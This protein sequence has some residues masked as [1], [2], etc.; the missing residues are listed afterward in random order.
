MPIHPYVNYAVALML[1]IAL[2]GIFGQPLAERGI[3]ELFKPLGSLFGITP[4]ASV[5]I[6]PG[7]QILKPQFRQYK[8]EEYPVEAVKVNG[9]YSGGDCPAGAQCVKYYCGIESSHIRGT[10]CTIEVMSAAYPFRV[11][12]QSIPACTQTNMCNAPIELKVQDGS[13][14][15]LVFSA[16]IFGNTG[17]STRL[18]YRQKRLYLYDASTGRVAGS[19]VCDTC[20]TTCLVGQSVKTEDLRVL[21]VGEVIESVA[22]WQQYP[23]FDG[24]YIDWNGQPAVCMKTGSRESIVQNL[25]KWSNRPCYYYHGDAVLARGE[26]CPGET[27]LGL[28]C[29]PVTLKFEGTTPRCCFGSSCSVSYCPGSG[30][31]PAEEWNMPGDEICAYFCD[32][33]TGFC[34]QD[35]STCETW[36]C[37]PETG[38]GCPSTQRCD[39]VTKTCTD[40]PIIKRKCW[41]TGR[42]CCIEPEVDPKYVELLTCAEAGFPS[43]YV[44]KNGFCYDPEPDDKCNYDGVCDA[45]EKEGECP[46]CGCGLICQLM[47]FIWLWIVASIIVAVALLVISMFYPAL[48]AVLFMNPLTGLLLVAALGLLLALFFSIPVAMVASMVGI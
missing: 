37:N 32:R 11:I 2:L 9:L 8:C 7:C 22:A 3:A 29:N 28:E 35:E 38:E 47:R 14:T 34:M 5:S 26:C 24:N 20:D 25:V 1:V 15:I 16:D 41:E 30:G 43:D 44:C 21:N 46:D 48:K 23:A 17:A 18:R 27:Y 31:L 12:G 4:Q 19:P 13:K 40:K 10:R 36:K 45:N 39:P 33:A 42:E 6:E